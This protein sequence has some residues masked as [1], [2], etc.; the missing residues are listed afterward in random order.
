M[1]SPLIHRRELAYSLPYDWETVLGYFRAHQLPY[2]ETVDHSSYERVVQI[3]DHLGWF[4]VEHHP[5]DAALSLFVYGGTEK[6]VDDISAQVRR[7]FDLDANPKTLLDAMRA[8]PVLSKL[9]KLYPGLRVARS[10]S[11]IEVVYSAILGQVV[12]VKFGRVLMSELMQAAGSLALHPKTSE[13]IF[14][15]PSAKQIIEADLSSVRTSDTRRATIRAL[16]QVIERGVFKPLLAAGPAELRKALRAIPGIGPWTT[17]YV[18][19]RGLEDNDAF[20]A[21]DYALKQE[22]KRYPTIDINAIRPWRSYAAIA[23]WKGYAE[24][25]RS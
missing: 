25:K 3:R 12:S 2:L 21:T 7:M 11:A 23:L 8:D 13:P 16:A 18:A 5:S 10:W 4:R 14:L 6:D 20:P 24:A 17:E 1:A 19:M 22:L 15:F 9:W